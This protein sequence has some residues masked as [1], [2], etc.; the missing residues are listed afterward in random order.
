MLAEKATDCQTPL[1][2]FGYAIIDKCQS[3]KKTRMGDKRLW[4]TFNCAYRPIMVV[5]INGGQRFAGV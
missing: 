4:Q 1:R 5:S 2:L 3:E